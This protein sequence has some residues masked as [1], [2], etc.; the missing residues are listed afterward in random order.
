MKRKNKAT[1]KRKH[2]KIALIEAH[3]PSKTNDD[4]RIRRNIDDIVE[5]H[6]SL[7]VIRV[8]EKA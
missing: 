5:K 8:H 6:F 4:Q 7:P 2:D 3:G 1:S